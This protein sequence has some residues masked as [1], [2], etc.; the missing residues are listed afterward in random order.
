MKDIWSKAVLTTPFESQALTSS[1]KKQYEDD[2]RVNTMLSISTALAIIISCMGL[3]GLSIFVAER[4]IKEIGIRKVLGAS[5]PGIVGMLSKDFIKLVAISFI[6]AVPIGWYLMSQ[7]LKSFEYKITL[8]I[9]GFVLAGFV[10]FA[11]AWITIGFES[12]KAALGN[13]VNALR[14]E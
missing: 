14:S 7:W 6:V 8:G 10:S 1:V 2:A 4:K 9:M 11:I 5:I 13:P 12:V 3:Y